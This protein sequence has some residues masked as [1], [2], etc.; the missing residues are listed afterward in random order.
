MMYRV[1]YSYASAKYRH[2]GSAIVDGESAIS[3]MSY[4]QEALCGANRDLRVDSVNCVGRGL[5]ES[6]ADLL[7]IEKKYGA[8]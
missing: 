3:A 8:K 1:T 5:T 7:G 2:N 6:C 4:V